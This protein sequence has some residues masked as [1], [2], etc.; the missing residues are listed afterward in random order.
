VTSGKLDGVLLAYA[1]L[2][3]LGRISDATDFFDPADFLPCPGQG[4]LAV[5]CRED[6]AAL[7]E[8]LAPL[9]HR[10][11]RAAVV[12]ERAMLATLEAGCSAPVGGYAQIHP[13]NEQELTVTGVVAS[14]EPPPAPHEQ[15]AP[16]AAPQS[17][18]GTLTG[19]A[20]AAAR[21]GVE[22]AAQMLE[23]GA[24]ALMTSQGESL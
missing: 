2:N 17:V 7:R 21:L 9:D 22:L 18:R 10:P 5:E 6:D 4:A 11:T 20:E 24:A 12:A 15:S 23:Q 19:P 8:A 3:R 1:G 14:A 16:H 13:D